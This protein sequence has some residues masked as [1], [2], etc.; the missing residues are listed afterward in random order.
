MDSRE[1]TRR[2]AA[3]LDALVDQYR[4]EFDLTFAEVVGVLQIKSH[5]LCAECAEG[6]TGDEDEDED[7]G[8]EGP[9]AP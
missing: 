2:F 7:E 8:R 3:A 4:S 6:A 5:L 9:A 1:Q